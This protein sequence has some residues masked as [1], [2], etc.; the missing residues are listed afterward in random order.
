MAR[1]RC[2]P[3]KMVKLRQMVRALNAYNRYTKVSLT[4]DR[5]QAGKVQAADFVRSLMRAK[6]DE[7]LLKLFATG[8]RTNRVGVAL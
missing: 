5:G 7:K 8:S 6:A 4:K 1:K 3:E 2:K